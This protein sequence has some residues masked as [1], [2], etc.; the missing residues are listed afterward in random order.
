VARTTETAY[1]ATGRYRGASA[2]ERRAERRTQL[3]E[4]GLEL[5]GTVGRRETTVRGVCE[6]VG[7]NPRYF[8]ESFSDLDELVIAVFEHVAGETT[9]RIL[10]AFEDADDDARAKA[11]ATIEA[12]IHHLTDDPRRARVLFVE[13]LGDEGLGRRRLDTMHAMSQLVATYA[14]HFYGMPDDTDPIGDVAA[15]LLVGG[16]TESIIAWLDGRL[17]VDRER[18]IDDLTELWVITGE[19]AVGLARDRA[20]AAKRRRGGGGG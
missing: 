2:G 7:L 15:G 11:H 8:Y 17:E 5:L 19:G 4:A 10:E 18:L 1:Q 3:I 12:C 16:V 13:A 9:E 20:K 14:R 6:L